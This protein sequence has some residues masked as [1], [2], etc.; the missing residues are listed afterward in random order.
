V[1][2][3]EPQHPN[4]PIKGE[5]VEWL[6]ASSTRA[7]D[8]AITQFFF[9]TR[10]IPAVPRSL[11]RQQASQNRYARASCCD[12]LESQ[13]LCTVAGPAWPV[14]LDE[15][16]ARW[17]IRDDRHDLLSTRAL[18]ECVNWLSEGVREPALLSTAQTRPEPGTRRRGV[19]ALG[20]RA[21]I[22][23]DVRKT[24]SNLPLG[25]RKRHSSPDATAGIFFMPRACE[26]P[27]D[28]LAS[29]TLL[30]LAGWSSCRKFWT[31]PTPG[32]PSVATSA[33]CCT[34]FRT[35]RAVFRGT[36]GVQRDHP[37]GQCT[38]AG[39]APWLAF[40]RLALRCDD[41]SRAVGL[42]ELEYKN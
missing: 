34:T 21:N 25:Q 8:E 37:W 35:A 6:K 28:L 26:T 42:Y 17:A 19:R 41:K 23:S 1:P 14:A 12:Q 22:V 13:Q 2:T 27:Q 33:I 3:A 9:E 38:A 29:P 40:R 7:A 4:S 10:N 11:P 5:N 32:R 18:P 15:A 16:Y 36:P 24:T 31:L 20:G 39:T 30:R